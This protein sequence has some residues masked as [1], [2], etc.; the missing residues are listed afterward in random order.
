MKASFTLTKPI[1]LP[2]VDQI[3]YLKNFQTKTVRALSLSND[4]TKQ[5]PVESSSPKLMKT[6]TSQSEVQMMQ[7]AVTE[8]LRVA[9]PQVVKPSNSLSPLRRSSD[10]YDDHEDITGFYP[11][12]LFDDDTLDTKTP[13]EW[14]KSRQNMTTTHAYSKYFN[15]QGGYD[16]RPCS[17]LAYDSSQEKFLIQWEHTGKQKF[18]SR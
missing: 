7:T 9:S 12:Y 10:R 13:E 2:V 5:Q 16:W 6:T 8:M 17:V 3:R 4:T 15:N 1:S 14:V 18:V 11:L